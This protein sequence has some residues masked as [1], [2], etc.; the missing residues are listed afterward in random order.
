MLKYHTLYLNS[1]NFYY[2]RLIF[3][4][5][6]FT[7]DLIQDMLNN[8]EDLEDEGGPY[9]K[10]WTEGIDYYK[11]DGSVS[12]KVREECCNKFNDLKNTKYM[13]DF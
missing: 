3:S 4:Q 6:L 7:L 11:I 5:S 2:F 8:A 9:G 12:V 1:T 13:F 10:S